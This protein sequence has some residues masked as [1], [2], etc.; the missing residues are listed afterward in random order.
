MLKT[1]CQVQGGEKFQLSYLLTKSA[2][3]ALYF[4]L[5]DPFVLSATLCVFFF[6][7]FART[8]AHES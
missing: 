3:L 7:S 4:K 1:T 6:I 5:Q 8:A 2:A